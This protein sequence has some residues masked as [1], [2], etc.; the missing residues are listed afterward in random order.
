MRGPRAGVEC[1]ATGS[2]ALP[3]RF[4]GGAPQDAGGSSPQKLVRLALIF[5]V[6][7]RPPPQIWST[8]VENFEAAP[9]LGVYLESRFASQYVPG[10]SDF[11]AF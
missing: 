4:A 5:E 3:A 11:T 1:C 2:I 6:R 7:Y 8:N 9:E 10:E